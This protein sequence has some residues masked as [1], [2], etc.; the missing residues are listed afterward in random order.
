MG[1]VNAVKWENFMPFRRSGVSAV[2]VVGFF[3]VSHPLTENRSSNQSV[4][5]CYISTSYPLLFVLSLFEGLSKML[6]L[7]SA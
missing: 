3:A 6:A 2:A 7:A 1:G 5:R 4:A